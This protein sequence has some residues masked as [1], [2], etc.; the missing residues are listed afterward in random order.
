MSANNKR[1]YQKAFQPPSTSSR[2][3]VPSHEVRSSNVA[4]SQRYH[5]PT[6]SPQV[7]IRPYHH[8]ET[9]QALKCKPRGNTI[10]RERPGTPRPIRPST[11]LSTHMAIPSPEADMSAVANAQGLLFLGASISVF[12]R[13]SVDVV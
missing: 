8:P 2:T 3:H 5:I 10:L 11:P 12:F 4:L 7:T 1:R 9:M 6:R 13:Q